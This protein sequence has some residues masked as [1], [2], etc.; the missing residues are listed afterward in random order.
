MFI[1]DRFDLRKLQQRREPFFAAMPGFA[2]TPK[3]Q[4]DTTARAEAI[5][6]DLPAAQL[7][8]HALLARTIASPDGRH[9]AIFGWLCRND[10]GLSLRQVL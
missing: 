5:D 4:L 8:C 1:D 10:F 6:I 3:R 2:H 9:Q 7:F